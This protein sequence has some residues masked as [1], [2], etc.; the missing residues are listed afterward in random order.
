MEKIRAA[1]VDV[2]RVISG[3]TRDLDLE[4][5]DHGYGEVAGSA[6]SFIPRG[7]T[8]GVVLPS[9]SPGVHALWVP[10]IALRIALVLKPGSAEPWTPYPHRSRPS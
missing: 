2:E 9:N 8:L 6:V 1:M 5:L 4:L 10:T 3:L 7:P